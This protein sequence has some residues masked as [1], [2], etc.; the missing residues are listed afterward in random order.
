[1]T[2]SL[3]E[4]TSPSEMY[5]YTKKDPARGPGHSLC[6]FVFPVR[7]FMFLKPAQNASKL[8]LNR[9]ASHDDTPASWTPIPTSGV[10]S[11]ARL[12]GFGV[13]FFY[14]V[15]RLDRHVHHVGAVVVE[16]EFCGTVLVV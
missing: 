12:A 15:L 6:P 1:M 11:Q 5:T 8:Q 14:K 7:A 13:L 9:T 4:K 16:A 10:A 2:P 3:V